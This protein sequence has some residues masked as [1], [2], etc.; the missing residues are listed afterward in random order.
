MGT[1]DEL[2]LDIL[3]NAL[4]TFSQEQMGV[5]QLV[6]GESGWLVRV[7]GWVGGRVG[8]F[9]CVGGGCG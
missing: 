9:V 5:K 7:G 8:G 2:A 1:A 6:V 3:I 4:S